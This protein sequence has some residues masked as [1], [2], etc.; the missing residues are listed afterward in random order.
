MTFDEDKISWNKREVRER[1][2][3]DVQELLPRAKQ[4][5]ILPGQKP[6]EEINCIQWRFMRPS[7]EAFDLDAVA[8]EAARSCG[9]EAVHAN[10]A[11]GKTLAGREF[12][13]FDV[14]LCKSL[15]TSRR[16]IQ[17]VARHVRSA[18]SVFVTYERNEKSSREAKKEAEKYRARSGET[19]RRRERAEDDETTSVAERA[20]ENET[21]GLAEQASVQETTNSVEQAVTREATT[22]EERAS[23]VETTNRSERATLPETT[24]NPERA[25]SYETTEVGARVSKYESTKEHERATCGETTTSGER[26]REHETPIMPRRAKWTETTRV[27]ERASVQETTD[28]VERAIQCE[29]PI[30]IE[31]ANGAETTNFEEL[32]QLTDAQLGRVLLLE[33]TVREVKSNAQ[34]RRVYSYRGNHA[35]MLGVL[36]SFSKKT[37]MLPPFCTVTED[38]TAERK[39]RMSIAGIPHRALR[40]RLQRGRRERVRKF[41]TK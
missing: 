25:I 4:F 16:A 28:V 34:I 5:G 15:S 7:I 3:D 18:M 13:F 17:N 38:D 33:K 35:M 30:N 26:A 2:Y 10:V 21:T 23:R 29:T 14:D 9:V 31:R 1:L 40:S 27:R 6:S 37:K 20:R 8:V 11:F 24:T 39:Y 36:F 32:L 22:I 12:D 41:G 19:T